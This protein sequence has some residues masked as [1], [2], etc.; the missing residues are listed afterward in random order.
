MSVFTITKKHEEAAQL[1]AS[2]EL[3]DT[4]IAERLDVTRQTIWYWKKNPE[5]AALIDEHLDRFREE[6]LRRGLANRMRRVKA[7]NDRWNRLQ[8]IIEERA[9]HADYANAPGG[10]TGLLARTVKM[11]G[12]GEN[13]TVIEEFAVDVGLAKL[14]LEHEKQAAQ[15]LGQ[16][17][18]KQEVA[19]DIEKPVVVKVL[20]GVSM[21]DI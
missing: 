6:V 8:R 18:D 10:R 11:I 19:G 20:R 16:W 12:S 2:G 1:L 17:I 4:E 21:D 15:E 5:F 13:A 3:T 14:L 9:D 7:Q